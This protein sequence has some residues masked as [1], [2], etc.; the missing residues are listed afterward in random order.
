MLFNDILPTF[1]SAE[2]DC[3]R[4]GSHAFGVASLDFEVVCCVKGQ[5]LD[6]VSESVPHHRLNHP[7]VYL[8]IDISAVVDDVAWNNNKNTEYLQIMLMLL[9][10]GIDTRDRSVVIVLLP[11]ILPLASEGGCQ[12]TMMVRGRPSLLT[13]VTSFGAELGAEEKMP[14]LSIIQNRERLKMDEFKQRSIACRDPVLMESFT[15]IT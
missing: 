3:V 10:I 8:G 9:G 5:L 7:V 13:T 6:L 15:Q 1:K 4:H 11:V 2:L 14:L 12:L